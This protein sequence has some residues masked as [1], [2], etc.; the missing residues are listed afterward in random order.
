MLSRKEELKIVSR[1]R[2]FQKPVMAP[3]L[4]QVTHINDSNFSRTGDDR[5]VKDIKYKKENEDEEGIV[6]G[7]TN[8]R[9]HHPLFAFSPSEFPKHRWPIILLILSED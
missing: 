1:K 6:D 3:S 7:V 5:T 4:P 9:Q 8:Q 2:I